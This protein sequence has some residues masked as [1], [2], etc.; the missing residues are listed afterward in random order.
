MG[1]V[2]GNEIVTKEIKVVKK[3]KIKA[4]KPR[5]KENQVDKIKK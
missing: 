1:S 3:P 4:I 5:K 2:F